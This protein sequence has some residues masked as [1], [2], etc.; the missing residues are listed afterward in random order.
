MP[1]IR[2]VYIVIFSLML[3]KFSILLLIL[4]F[5]LSAVGHPVFAHICT[6]TGEKTLFGCESCKEI[7]EPIVI[8]ETETCCSSAPE[9]TVPHSAG[10]PVYSVTNDECCFDTFD[11]KKIQDEF[12]PVFQLKVEAENSVCGTISVD[13]IHA[14]Q[15]KQY[16]LI[17]ENLPPPLSGIHLLYSLHQLKIGTRL[18]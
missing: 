18:S 5:T 9:E 3:K 14:Q 16:I 13:E 17:S 11:Y 4:L 8:P 1:L 10:T 6:I 15:E 7:E 2:D 12:S